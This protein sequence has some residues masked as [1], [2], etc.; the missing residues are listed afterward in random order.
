MVDHH[1]AFDALHSPDDFWLAPDPAAAAGSI[2]DGAASLA[3]SGA[4]PNLPPTTAA[5]I[6][7]MLVLPLNEARR[8]FECH[9]INHYLRSHSSKARAA[10]AMGLDRGNLIHKLAHMKKAGF[11]F[12]QPPED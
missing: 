1:E 12:H 8:V 9:Y 3:P 5:A 6:A 7:R 4:G 11:E 10:Q 2:R